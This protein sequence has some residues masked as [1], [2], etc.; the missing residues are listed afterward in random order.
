MLSPSYTT[1]TPCRLAG[2]EAAQRRWPTFLLTSLASPFIL[3]IPVFIYKWTTRNLTIKIPYTKHYILQARNTKEYIYDPS[4]I[5]WGDDATFAAA[6]WV[7][8]QTTIGQGLVCKLY[9]TFNCTDR[10]RKEVT[11]IL[12]QKIGGILC[13]LG[14]LSIYFHDTYRYLFFPF[15][16][17]VCIL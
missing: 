16:H 3:G 13:A 7:S 5:D 17:T 14:S 10:L 4:Q 1:L 11:P 6:E 12:L 2:I 8:D 15:F 9:T